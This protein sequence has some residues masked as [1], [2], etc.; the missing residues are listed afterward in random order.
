MEVQSDRIRIAV[1]GLPDRRFDRPQ[2][3]D[4]I[5]PEVRSPSGAQANEGTAFHHGTHCS[6]ARASLHQGISSSG[7]CHCDAG[8]RQSRSARVLRAQDF[9]RGR[10]M[11][12]TA[13]SV[14]FVATA[15]A[16]CANVKTGT[17]YS[18]EEFVT[19]SKEGRMMSM[20]DTYVANRKFEQVVAVLKQKSADCLDSDSV[21][22]R[23]S[24][25]IQ[26]MRVTDHFRTT[27]RVVAPGR[28]E[29]TTQYTSSGITYLQKIPDGG[30]YHRAV[31]VERLT[32]T[33]TKLTFYGSSFSES[34]ST[35]AAMKKWSDGQSDAC[36]G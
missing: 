11:Q 31:D 7:T 15:L 35:W 5:H 23:R 30:F 24:G 6:P 34:K 28:A 29:L 27:V 13:L 18:R 19:Y 17:W 8:Q 33:T 14:L 2:R 25:G 21:M 36:L 26:T 22:S 20:T 9:Q 32:P 10:T 3:V 1:F 12:K 4:L 16:G